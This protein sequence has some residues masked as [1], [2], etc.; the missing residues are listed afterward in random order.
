MT[1]EERYMKILRRNR[2]EL[3]KQD[4]HKE[5]RKGINE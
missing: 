3:D 1:S 5:E 2:E 4:I